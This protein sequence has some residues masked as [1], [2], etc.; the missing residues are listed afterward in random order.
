VDLLTAAYQKK[1]T[2]EDFAAYVYAVLA[3]PGYTERFWDELE[4]CEVRVPITKDAVHFEESAAIGRRLLWLHTYAQRFS[5]QGRSANQVPR[6]NARCT[7]AV[8]DGPEHYPRQFEYDAEAGAL[9][10]GGD[11]LF[12][13][14][15]GVF[16]PV[17]REVYEFEVSGL[18]VVQ[19]WLAYRM[20]KRRGKASSPLDDIRPQAWTPEFTT[21]LLE[22]LWVVEHTLGGYPAQAALL[23]RIVAGP[24]FQSSDFPEPPAAM[25]K[26][27]KPVADG[28]QLALSHD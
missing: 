14:Q 17:A 2:A 20:A 22:L 23:D 28:E 24:L 16:A 19:S 13:Q 4:R 10:V 5:G 25:R 18:K 8:P 26:P 21:Q 11:E 1:V 27:P 15:A 9:R 3:H 6:G 12:E 7:A